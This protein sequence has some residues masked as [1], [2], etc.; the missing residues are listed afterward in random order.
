MKRR[1]FLRN[2]LSALSIPLIFQGQALG[3]VKDNLFLK[4]L[5][6]NNKTRKLVIIQLDGG[7]DGLNMFFPITQYRNLEKARPDII[8]PQNK[9]LN[10]TDALMLHP[11]MTNFKRMY[12]AQQALIIQNVGYPN[13]NLSHFRSKDIIATASDAEEVLQSGWMGRYLNEQY[14]DYPNEY[15]CEEVSDPIAIT[16]GSSNTLTTHGSEC[17]LGV[18]LKNTDTA[19]SHPNTEETSYP[20]TPFGHELKFISDTMVAS[21]SY[22]NTLTEKAE[23]VE[24]LSTLYPQSKNPL[25]DQLAL[26]AR[27]ISGGVETQVY[28][29]SLGGFDTHANQ[30]KSDTEPESG[31][32]ADLLK[33]LSDAIRAFQDDLI[34]M[35]KDDE[36]IGFVYSEFGRRIK[37]N[38]QLGTDHGTSFP[39]IMFG[40]QINPVTLGKVPEISDKVEPDQNLDIEFDI[41][42]IYASVFKE[43]FEA[44]ETTISE[45]LAAEYE[46]LPVLK[47]SSESSFYG[48]SNLKVTIY[49]NPATD[50]IKLDI[51][52][53][54]PQLEIVLFNELGQLSHTFF[55]QQVEGNHQEIT[56]PIDAFPRGNYILQVR[57]NNKSV[58]KKIIF[59]D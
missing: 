1:N 46:T 59:K 31:T 51:F 27:L 29:L 16:I 54:E 25:A 55:N 42:S 56:L 40:S 24:N 30:V 58:T 52:N 45:L 13:M 18:V 3:I 34:L 15:P 36:V 57:S 23:S 35:E 11:S 39:A 4:S 26:V 10:L 33:Q 22:L 2:S 20:E 9:L 7:N 32:H 17:N 28:M 6:T 38:A 49:P 12:D 8:I 21:E 5:L 19:Y 14:P 37:S 44:D 41:R 47:S 43:W 53:E 50:Y 48:N